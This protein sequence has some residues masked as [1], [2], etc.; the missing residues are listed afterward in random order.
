VEPRLLEL[1]PVLPPRG[2]GCEVALRV[3][4][5]EL[6]RDFVEVFDAV[7]RSRV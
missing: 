1:T 3:L 5:E 7:G 4:P 2:D 6:G